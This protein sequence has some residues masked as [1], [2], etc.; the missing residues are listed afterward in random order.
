MSITNEKI[1]I[2]LA[3]D[4]ALIRQAWSFMLNADKRFKVIAQ[5]SNGEEAIEKARLHHP[6]IIVI[7]INMPGIT[8]VEAVKE[9]KKVSPR[10]RILAASQHVHQGYVSAMIAA[11]ANG[12]LTKTSEMEEMFTAILEINDGGQYIC[13]E[14]KDKLATR[15]LYNEEEE[16]AEAKLS[17]REIVIIDLIRKGVSS[18]QMAESLCIS[19]KTVEVHRYNILK[20]LNLKNSPALVNFI[21]ENPHMLWSKVA[22]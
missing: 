9:I 15:F 12:Y 14:I 22:I 5:C 1:T 13:R 8:G 17:Q 18:K 16:A 11:G 21:N 10:S 3:D 19:Q 2:M 4:H 20:K 7:D 6:D